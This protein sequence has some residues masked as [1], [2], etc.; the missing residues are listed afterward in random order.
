M[1][2]KRSGVMMELTFKIILMLT[3]MLLIGHAESAKI[4]CVFPTAS[5]SH[6]LGAQALLKELGLRGH[7][8]TMVSAFPLKN[9]PKNYRDVYVP[10]EDAFSTIM[11]DFMQGGSRNMMKLFPKIVRAA[12]DS[13]NVTINAPEF[14]H[15][16]REEQFDLAIVGFFMNSFIIG[17]G[18]LFRCPTVLYF[19]AS[20]SGLT[21][22]VGNPIEVATVPHMMLGPRNPM[23]FLDRVTNTLLHGMEKIMLISNFPAEK[24]FRSYDAAIRNVSLVMLNTYFSQYVPRPYLPNM[25]EV[26]GIQIN[27]RPE[28]MPHELQQFLDNAGPEGAIFISFGS[29]L[30][31]SNLRQDKLDAILMMIRGLKQR[32][33]WKWDQ[34]EMPNRPPNVF[35]GKWLPQDVILAHPNLKLFIT[36]GGLGSITEA[37]YYGVP[38]VGIPMFGDQD[39]NVAQVV[40]EGWGVMV[41]FDDLTEPLLSGAVQQVLSDP[42]YREHVQG[43][44]ILYKDRPLGALET[45]V[46][47]IEYI[48]RHH[49][50][51]VP[52]KTV[53]RMKIT[54]GVAFAWVVMCCCFA[55]LEA[56][57]ILCIFPSSG[58][59]HVLVGQALLKG[60]AERGHDVTMVSP[61]KLPKPVTNYREIVVQKVDLG[62]MTRDFLQKNQ[63]N[64]MG[65]IVHLFQSQFRTAEMAL[66]DAKFQTI[67]NEHFDL[68]IVGYFVAD[69]VLGLGPH[70]NAPTVVLFSAGM[71]KLTADFVGNPRAIATVPHIM[72]GGKGTMN[73]MGRVKNF[74]FA[75]FEN[76]ISV[77]SEYVQNSYYDRHFPPDRYPPFQEVRRN[78]SLVLLNTHFSHATPRPYLPNVVEVGG[79]QIKTKPD[80]L[81]E[82][83]REWLDGAEHGVIYFCLGS[84]LKSADLPQEKL[85]AILKTFANLKQRVL[86]KWES[87]RIPDAPSNVYSK[88]WLPQDD[89][90]AHPNVKLFI[91]HGGLGGMAEAKYH[92]VPVL[93]IPIFAEQFQNIQSMVE[94]G[95]AMRLDYQELDER[96]FSRAVNI[97][98]REHRYAERAKIISDLYRD[99]PQSAMELACYWVEYVARHRGAPHLHYSGADMNFFQL[100]SLDVLAFLCAVLYAIIKVFKLV[101]RLAFRK[102]FKSSRKTKLQ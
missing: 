52:T 86:W 29:N 81:P 73:F 16:V 12:Q 53:V 25:V 26:G 67:M 1:T 42:N 102:I 17:V 50:S 98:M 31:S 27:V 44:S 100:E 71:T 51:G 43:R 82:D 75:G 22:V 79:L 54:L 13:S 24:G 63:G 70:F 5:K 19:S 83:I 7:E 90:L 23:T 61:F 48:I 49:E 21:N 97:M 88:A 32:V 20:G 65:G 68:V 78:V 62:E 93:G 80:P 66:E 8:V 41:S 36:H 33:I 74:L 46:F 95:V 18:E 72:L 30:R 45:G 56:Y 99:R 59:S 89:V 38:I 6:V 84:N 87:E 9:P 3:L 77:V 4:V 64:S 76:V 39:G 2:E 10:I 28:P 96:S 14:I 15:L 57:R 35:I 47:W 37:M 55:Q 40:K 34:D 58:R 92:G 11:N 85:D 101:I 91:A 60:L 69:F 94:E